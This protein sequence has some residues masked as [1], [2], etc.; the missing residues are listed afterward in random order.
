MIRFWM[1]VASSSFELD[2]NWNILPLYTLDPL[3]LHI[4]FFWK[5]ERYYS[6][7]DSLIFKKQS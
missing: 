4:T 2:E 5:C 3:V 1:R 7:H 6:I